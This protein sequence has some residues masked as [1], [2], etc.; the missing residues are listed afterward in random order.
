MSSIVRSFFGQ[1]FIYN[2]QHFSKGISKKVAHIYW[3]VV[4]N[5][6]NVISMLKLDVFTFS[7]LAT[8]TKLYINLFFF[9]ERFFCT[10]F[11]ML[12]E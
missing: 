4:V 1:T 12:I 11:V 6:Y 9:V 8:K 10:Y 3:F 7:C 2:L 5:R